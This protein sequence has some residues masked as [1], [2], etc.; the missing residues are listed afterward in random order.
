ML[1]TT[2]NYTFPELIAGI[3]REVQLGVDSPAVQAFAIEITQNQSDKI[4]AVFNWTRAHMVYQ[5]DPIVDGQESEML[6]SPNFQVLDYLK[7]TAIWEDCD[8]HAIF[9]TAIFRCL[10]MRSHVVIIDQ[11]GGGYDHALC[12][13]YSDIHQKWM[14]VD[15]S[16]DKYPLGW[17][18][19]SFK[20][21]IV[22]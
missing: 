3:Q 7:G 13:V 20:E 21:Y 4:A 15:S 6:T 18:E 9:N 14:Y 19:T 8:G 16:T 17:T 11:T 10:G 2:E 12:R 22:S 1:T 5:H